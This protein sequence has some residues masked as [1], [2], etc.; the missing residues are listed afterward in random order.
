[1]LSDDFGMNYGGVGHNNLCIDPIAGAKQLILVQERMDAMQELSAAFITS[2][3][4]YHHKEILD[5]LADPFHLFE[6]D[7]ALFT[8]CPE[9]DLLQV[10]E[11][12][13]ALPGA[14]ERLNSHGCDD[15]I[16]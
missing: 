14:F 1:M 10:P 4:V 9:Q 12:I 11:S 15:S 3:F 6:N 7:A 13:V 5:R 2:N 8:G 16:R